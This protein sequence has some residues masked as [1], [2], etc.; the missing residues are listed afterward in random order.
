[1]TRFPTRR[2]LEVAQ[3]ELPVVRTSLLFLIS[4]VSALFST[5]KIFREKF[6]LQVSFVSV[7]CPKHSH[8]RVGYFPHRISGD[9]G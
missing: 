2:R 7:F 9:I 8:M 4:G 3:P 1:M 6:P 5:E